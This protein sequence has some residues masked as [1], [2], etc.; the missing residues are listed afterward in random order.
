M[1]I[2]YLL[3]PFICWWTQVVYTSWLL[4]IMLLCQHWNADISFEIMTS[5]PLA[6]FPEVELLAHIVVL[7]LIFRGLHTVFHSDCTD[8]HSHQQCTRVP[9][10]PHPHQHS[11]SIVFLTIAILTDWGDISFWFGLHFLMISHVEYL[12]MYLL[13]ICIFSLENICPFISSVY[14]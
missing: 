2:P 5:F 9:V 10:S 11:W 6:I 1:Y 7:F 12:S 13:S 14:F 8:L 4:W 3:Y